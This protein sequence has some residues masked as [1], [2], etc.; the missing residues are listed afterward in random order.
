MLLR[1]QLG[2]CLHKRNALTSSN[3]FGNG[4]TMLTFP[5]ILILQHIIYYHKIQQL[6]VK[7]DQ[8]F[9][10]PLTV[11]T[12]IWRFDLITNRSIRRSDIP[13]IAHFIIQYAYPKKF[14]PLQGQLSGVFTD[15]WALVT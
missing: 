1:L 5:K 15:C 14:M 9:I 11:R 3:F 6:V 10:N 2:K 8:K 13:F 4:R 7:F 12:T